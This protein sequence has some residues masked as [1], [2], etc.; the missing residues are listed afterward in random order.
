MDILTEDK[1]KEKENIESFNQLIIELINCQKKLTDINK[2]N[3]RNVA[4]EII[5][6]NLFFFITYSSLALLIQPIHNLILTSKTI[7]V[8]KLVSAYYLYVK[9]N[10]HTLIKN[11]E[12]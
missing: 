8:T 9:T 11:Q 12:L 5:I 1:E 7:K 10:T 4:R 2:E 6:I 3:P